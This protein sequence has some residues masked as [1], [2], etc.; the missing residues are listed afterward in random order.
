VTIL[1]YSQYAQGG[2]ISRTMPLLV[3]SYEQM[4]VEIWFRMW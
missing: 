4:E 2:V 3:S 1:S